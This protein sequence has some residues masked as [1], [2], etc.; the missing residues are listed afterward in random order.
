MSFFNISNC[1]ILIAI[2]ILPIQCQITGKSINLIWEQLDAFLFEN[3]RPKYICI[4][5]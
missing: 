2:G 4:N 3:R 1:E 5:Q